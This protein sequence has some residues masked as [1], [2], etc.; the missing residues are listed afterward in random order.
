VWLAEDFF[1]AQQLQGL[2]VLCVQQRK[3]NDE[4]TLGI[5]H[6]LKSIVPQNTPM[7]QTSALCPQLETTVY[8]L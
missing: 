3:I 7:L 2:N 1:V 4:R 5:V 6:R 8:L